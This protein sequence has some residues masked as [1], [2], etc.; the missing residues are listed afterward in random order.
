M[1][2]ADG[3][4]ANGIDFEPDLCS[5]SDVSKAIKIPAVWWYGTKRRAAVRCWLYW[6][7]GKA[8]FFWAWF[9]A[10]SC[11]RRITALTNQVSVLCLVLAVFRLT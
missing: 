5:N 1:L 3:L 10:L 4:D 6:E 8:A 11:Q 2:S 7:H 9:A